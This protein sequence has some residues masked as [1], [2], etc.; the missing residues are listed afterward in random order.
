[1]AADEGWTRRVDRL[2]GLP[3]ENGSWRAKCHGFQ[4][5]LVPLNSPVARHAPSDSLIQSRATSTPS[6][7][8]ALANWNTYGLAT[9]RFTTPGRGRCVGIGSFDGL[10]AT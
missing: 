4:I 2:I 10:S 1:M 9:W 5:S 8:G 3:E 7:P 6:R